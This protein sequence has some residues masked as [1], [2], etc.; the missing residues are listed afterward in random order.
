[1]LSQALHPVI[2][3]EAGLESALDWYLPTIERQTGIDVCY[4]KSGDSFPIAS[5][6]GIHVYRIVQEA[7]N[8]AARHSGADKVL[9]RLRFGEKALEVEVEDHGKGIPVTRSGRGIG[10]V[11]MRERAELLHGNLEFATPNGGGTLVRLMVPREQ[12]DG[13]GK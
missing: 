7:L 8:N 6:A 4:E 9:V 12:F 10:I 13:Q 2:L 11:A 1:M 3:D 5:H